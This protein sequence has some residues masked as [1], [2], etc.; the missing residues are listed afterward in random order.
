MPG[1]KVTHFYSMRKSGD[2]R[3][4]QDTNLVTQRMEDVNADSEWDI[5]PFLAVGSGRLSGNAA[6]LRVTVTF[7]QQRYDE[8]A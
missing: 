6:L 4:A 3:W 5:D 1:L 2:V 7:H 8:C